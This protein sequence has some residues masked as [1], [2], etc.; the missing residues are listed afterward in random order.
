MVKIYWKSNLKIKEDE[1]GLVFIIFLNIITKII[2]PMSST[3]I[4]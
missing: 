1:V 3:S 4:E 2:T